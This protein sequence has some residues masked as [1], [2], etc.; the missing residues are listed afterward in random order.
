MILLLS[1]RPWLLPATIQSR[2]QTW[3]LRAL[4]AASSID[5]LRALSVAVPFGIR[6]NARALERVLSVQRKVESRSVVMGMVETMLSIDTPVTDAAAVLQRFEL[7]DSVESV[8]L[9]L[10]ARLI[11]QTAINDYLW[12]YLS[13]IEASHRSCSECTVLFR[14]RS[15]C[16]RLYDRES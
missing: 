2:C 5:H 1:Q 15:L 12:H 8:V 13:Y 3:R 10:E 14:R 6:G 4:K 16:T 9:A 7:I 11:D